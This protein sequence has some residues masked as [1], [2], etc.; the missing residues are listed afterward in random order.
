MHIYAMKRKAVKKTGIGEAAEL[1]DTMAPYVAP[2]AMLRTQ[3]Y[4]TRAEHQFVQGEANRTGQ[5][6]AS[7]IRSFIDEKMT[8][9]ED[10][11]ANNP[12]LQPP[13]EDRSW[14]GHEDGAINHDHYVYGCPKKWIKRGKQWVETPPLPEDYYENRAS[15]ER[16]DQM[17]REMDESSR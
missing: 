11:W 12:M 2:A 3:I 17:L 6:M 5:P 1:H 15:A 8:V 10:A 4:L 16:Y 9:P 14:K 7:V 13:V